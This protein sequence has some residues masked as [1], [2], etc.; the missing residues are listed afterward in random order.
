VLLDRCDRLGINA[1]SSLVSSHLV[2]RL[3][4]DVTPAD[5]V[6]QRVE[7]S[8]R[9]LLGHSP[10]PLLKASYVVSGTSPT[11]GVGTFCV[12][13]RAR[14]FFV[15]STHEVVY[16]GPYGPLQGQHMSEAYGNAIRSYAFAARSGRLTADRLD[17]AFLT[18]CEQQ[19]ESAG[20][21]ALKWSGQSAYGTSFPENT[22]HVL[23]GGWYFSLDQA[24]DMI[25]ADQ[26]DYPSGNDPRPQFLSAFLANMN[27]EAGTNPVNIAYV[28]GIGRKRQ[29]EIV[30][31]YAQNDRRVMPPSGLPLGNIQGGLPYINL[32]GTELSAL[33]F[34]TDS[35]LAGPYPY[36]DRWSD[37]YN[38]ST[39]FVVVNQARALA[40]LAWLA[41]QTACG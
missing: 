35:G 14:T 4:Q 13:A 19:I 34:P 23:G 30:H 25:V 6:V 39:E 29:R 18:K 17:A 36:Y 41:A 22:K 40:G 11:G 16:H 8:T 10:Q 9:L 28:T 5:A 20:R 2:P 31:Q 24:F 21:D 15:D 33:S 1:R 38:V 27:Y 32:Y 3:V 26:L 37:T 12:H 7:L